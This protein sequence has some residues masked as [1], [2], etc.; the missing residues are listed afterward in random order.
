MEYQLRRYQITPG[1]LDEFVEAWASGVVPLREQFGFRFRGAWSIPES[2]EFVWIIGYDGPDGL[3]AAD[4]R[5]YES[6]ERRNLLP[7]PAVHIVGSDHKTVIPVFEPDS[8]A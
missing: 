4:A 6:D 2:N 5:Y 8:R 3:A 7:N 1:K